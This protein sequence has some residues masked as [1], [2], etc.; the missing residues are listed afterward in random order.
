MAVAVTRVRQYYVD[1]VDP[2]NIAAIELIDRYVSLVSL[3]RKYITQVNKDGP[4]IEVKHYDQSYTKKH[5]LIDE[6]KN[7]NI[8]LSDLKSDI[9]KHIK[10]DKKKNEKPAAPKIVTKEDIL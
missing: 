6:I 1:Q 10:M 2:D 9:E 7:I 4:S 3:H 8:R 5:P